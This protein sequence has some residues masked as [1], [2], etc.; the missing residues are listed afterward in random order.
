MKSTWSRLVLFIF[1]TCFSAQAFELSRLP[2]ECRQCVI[3]TTPS[4]DATRGEL[5]LTERGAGKPWHLVGSSIPVRV[6]KRGLA[7]GRGLLPP[8]GF[9]GPQK[10]EGDDKA[11]AGIFRFGSAFGYAPRAP[12]TKLAYLP[13]STNIVAVDDSQSRYYNQVIDQSKVARRD[14]RHAEKMLLSDDRYKWGVVVKHNQ[15]PKGGVGS[16]IFLH[17]WKDPETP[18]TGCT[19]MPESALVDLIKWLEP[20]HHPLLIQ[21]PVHVYDQMKER[22]NLPERKI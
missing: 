17:V 7:W 8:P 11:P 19:A 15:P 2:A 4:W 6:G 10:I 22:W 13:L 20:D 18:T 3:V 21:L 14:W 16:C 5:Q 9:L 12:A 1:A